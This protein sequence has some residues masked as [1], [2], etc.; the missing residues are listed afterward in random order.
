MLA[1]GKTVEVFY[2][3]DC[4]LCVREIRMLRRKDRA[5][6]IVFTDIAAPT[7]DPASS[8]RPWPT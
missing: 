4:P 3:G 5:A 7:F 2:D 1:A 6:K 8:A